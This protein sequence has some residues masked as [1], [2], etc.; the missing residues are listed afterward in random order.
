[1]HAC[2][3]SFR[4]RELEFTI[5]VQL[6]QSCLSLF[7][8]CDVSVDSFLFSFVVLESDFI[9]QLSLLFIYEW[10]GT[11]CPCENVFFIESDVP[12]SKHCN[13]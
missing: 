10:S 4:F 6:M 3:L 12:V 2:A 1:M 11:C 8:Y 13:E 5:P 7:V 9:Y